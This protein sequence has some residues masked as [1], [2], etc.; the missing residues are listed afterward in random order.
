MVIAVGTIETKTCKAA[1]AEV[2]ISTD[3][4]EIKVGDIFYVNINID[5][6]T[7][8]GNFEAN[9]IYDDSL[10]QYNGGASVISGNSGFLHITDT[11]LSE[12]DYSR[13]YSLE[14]E[15][16]KVG[17]STVDFSGRIMI[18]D[19][20]TDREMP[21]S[22][23]VLDVN[24]KAQD[25]ASSDAKLKTLQISPVGL[26]PAFDPTIYEYNINVGN[27]TQQL[28]IT[29]LPEDS[30]AT[31]SITGNDFLKEGD[32]N[33]VISVLAETG[34]IIEYKI[35]AYREPATDDQNTD[36][37]DNPSDM[38]ESFELIEADGNKYAVFSGKY[39]I[40]EPDDA[41]TIP[42][43]YKPGSLTISGITIPAYMPV[44]NEQSEFVLI[45]A[46]NEFGDKGFYKYDRIEKTLQ[47]YIDGGLIINNDQSSQDDSA[48]DEYHN[49]MTKAVFVIVLLCAIC[50]L[51]TFVTVRMFIKLKGYKDDDLD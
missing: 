26:N 29:A 23:N 33:V 28:I 43:G 30:K 20:E 31:V 39:A 14:F 7:V 2:T 9:L 8:F 3:S 49:N 12:G 50:I 32:N 19:F 40:I 35:K 45:Y 46:R 13:K 21:V 17:K 5:S 37:S 44:D 48:A 10:M 41:V 25:T 6:D 15:A 4:T 18:Y 22:N 16:L 47:R 24:I 27:E 11:N 51:M 38:E 1:S 34:D 42:E 36:I